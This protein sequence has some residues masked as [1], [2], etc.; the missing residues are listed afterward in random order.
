MRAFFL[1]VIAYLLVLVL[2][3]IIVLIKSLKEKNKED[4]FFNVAIGFDQ[5]GGSVIYKTEDW[6]VSS[7]TY[8]LCKY[9]GKYCWFRKFIDFI[10]GKGHCEHS[11]KKESKEGMR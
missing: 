7:W 11:Y 9:K 8:Y 5:A 2:T 6:T 4:Y 3:P 1:M 10:F